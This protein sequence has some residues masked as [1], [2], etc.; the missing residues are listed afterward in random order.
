[1]K[2]NKNQYSRTEKIQTN[3]YIIESRMHFMD[4]ES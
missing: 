3:D 1:M 4:I 2:Q